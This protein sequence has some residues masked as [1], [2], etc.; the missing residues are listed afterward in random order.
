M[1]KMVSATCPSCSASLQFE[2]GRR[3]GFCNY[4]GAK[5]II[6]NENEHIYRH[7]DEAELRRAEA[8]YR[9]AEAEAL[10]N[11]KKLEIE[12]KDKER[13]LKIYIAYAIVMVVFA[14]FGLLGKLVYNDT[15]EEAGFCVA[16]LMFVVAMYYGIFKVAAK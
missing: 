8:E 3:E 15:L 14:G 9:R 2:E 11:L 6:D 12:Q 16:G 7:I 1:I 5:V 10:L 4:C 13:K